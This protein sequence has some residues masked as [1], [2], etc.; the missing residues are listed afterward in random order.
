MRDRGLAQVD[1]KNRVREALRSGR[2]VAWLRDSVS[3]ETALGPTIPSSEVDAAARRFARFQGVLARLFADKGWDG[4]VRS[5]LLDA[6]ACAGGLVKGDHDLPITGS[7]KE[8]GGVHALL[9]IVERISDRCHLALDRL[10]SAEAG[11]VLGRHTIVVASTGNLGFSVGVFAR[12]FGLQAQVH[13]SADARGWK[14]ERLREAGAQ[15]VEHRCDY[16]ETL[17][18]ARA[19]ASATTCWLIDDESGR[20]LLTGYAVAGAEVREQLEARGTVVDAARPLVAYLPCGIGGAPGG[21]TYGL[22]RYF[23]RAVV[24][25]FVEPVASPCMLAALALG[26]GAP[27]SVYDYGCDNQTIADGLQVPVASKLVLDAVGG[28]V[29]AAISVSDPA[30]LQWMATLWDWSRL[31]LEPSAAAAFAARDLLLSAARHQ[32]GWPPLNSATHLYWATGG[33]QLPKGEFTR[34]LGAGQ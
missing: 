16:S 19:A 1:Q 34:L 21:I 8:R 13:M 2:E 29:D 32:Q 31:Q 3:D 20:D 27:V 12:A 18:R 25:V 30:M 26:N 11:D 4:L 15:V 23:G 7:I 22:K 6:P 28:A 10:A 24:T 17:Q 14:K 9:A 33:S 5:A